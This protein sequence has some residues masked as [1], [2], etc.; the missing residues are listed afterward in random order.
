MKTLIIAGT[1]KPVYHTKGNET[2]MHVDY[3]VMLFGQSQAHPLCVCFGVINYEL[4]SFDKLQEVARA[5]YCK[6]F[7]TDLFN[8]ISMENLIMLPS[9]RKAEKP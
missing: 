7:E 5:K 3:N 1:A 9:K 4:Q 6:Y 2:R 8:I